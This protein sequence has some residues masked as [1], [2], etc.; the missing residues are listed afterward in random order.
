M[1]LVAP[2]VI[3][4]ARVAG[5]GD[6]DVAVA[7]AVARGADHDHAGVPE[8]LDRFDQRVVAGRLEH[9]VA[10]GQVDD[11]DAV[12]VLVVADPL[13]AGQD[14]RGQAAPEAVEHAHRDQARLRG[15]AGQCGRRS[16]LPLPTMMPATCVPWP[17]GSMLS[18]GGAAIAHRVR[19]DVDD[20]GQGQDVGVKARRRSRP[21]RRHAGALERA[22]GRGSGRAV[23]RL[24]GDVHR[25]HHRLVDPDVVDR[26]VVGEGR[27]RGARERAGTS[28]ATTAL[29]WR[30]TW[31]PVRW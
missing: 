4:F 25:G 8:R 22:L 9:R 26:R 18:S 19:D 10:E 16:R 5:A 29:S 15:D 30:R 17:L 6:G 28:S 21:R 14:V 13:Q 11:A 1:S 20:R 3:T 24:A 2:T 7:A 12:F 23:G 31:P 27:G